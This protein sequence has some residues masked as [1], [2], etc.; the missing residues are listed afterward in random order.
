[1]F[2]HVKVKVSEVRMSTYLC[3]NSHIPGE[4][5]LASLPSIFFL[6]IG[7]VAWVSTVCGRC[8]S[9]YQVN[10]MKGNVALAPTSD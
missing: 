2:L 8:P 3:F 6:D 5:W 7:E 9:C 10:V 4:S 1:M